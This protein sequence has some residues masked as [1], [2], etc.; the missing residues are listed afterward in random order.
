[1]FFMFQ[2]PGLTWADTQRVEYYWIDKIRDR[3]AIRL[4]LQIRLGWNFCLPQLRRIK[5]ARRVPHGP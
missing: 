1:M 3:R 5:R 4:L 2:D